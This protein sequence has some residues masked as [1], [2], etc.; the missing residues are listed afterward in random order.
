[1]NVA[2]TIYSRLPDDVRLWLRSRE[3]VAVSA[4]RERLVN[5]F[6]QNHC[7]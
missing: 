1:M 6:S 7:V 2:R 5:A 4:E 3:F